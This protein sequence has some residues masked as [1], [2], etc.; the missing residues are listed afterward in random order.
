[1]I[2]Y[3]VRPRPKN[4]LAKLFSPLN[5]SLRIL[6]T[7][8]KLCFVDFFV[9]FDF[10]KC[11]TYP[12]LGLN[13]CNNDIIQHEPFWSTP[14]VCW[15]KTACYK[16]CKLIFL[17][18]LKKDIFSDL[19]VWPWPTNDQFACVFHAIFVPISTSDYIFLLAM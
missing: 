9:R 10:T 4:A 6:W 16:L 12:T 15:K 1:V 3:P 5:L 13:A 18:R 19:T 7:E 2:Y 8:I 11:S 17:S 14:A